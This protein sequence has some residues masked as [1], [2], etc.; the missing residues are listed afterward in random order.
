MS[1]ERPSESITKPNG[2]L[3]LRFQRGYPVGR[4]PVFLARFGRQ[5]LRDL[6]GRRLKEL[7]LNG[8]PVESKRK[9]VRFLRTYTHCPVVHQW[10]DLGIR[11]WPRW[12]KEGKCHQRKGRSCSI[13]PGM[14]CK[15]SY[16]QS[17]LL[18][19]Y[20]CW[21]DAKTRAC[22]WIQVQYPIISA[23]KCEC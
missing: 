6:T 8:V 14:K 16:S 5:N 4:R 20:H 23:C 17:I 2:T 19:R 11:F 15:P 12:I 21:P 7:D 3:A 9:V 1:I 18:L 22:D 13:P 10:K